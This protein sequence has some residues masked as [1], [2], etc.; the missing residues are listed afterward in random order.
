MKSRPVSKT[1][2]KRALE[3]IGRPGGRQL[4]FLQEHYSS[5][6]R[7]STASKLGMAA[8]YKNF[9]ALNLQYGTLARRLG[10]ALGMRNAGLGLLLEF[11]EPDSLT[12]EHWILSMKPAFADALRELDWVQEGASRR[13]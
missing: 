7:A 5:P 3:L 8:G 1:E 10:E 11:N 6:G 2:Y 4:R 9:N 13:R 12:N